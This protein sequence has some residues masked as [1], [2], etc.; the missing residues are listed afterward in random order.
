MK[1]CIL[2]S[3]LA[4]LMIAGTGNAS[5]LATLEEVV[6]TGTRFEREV[7]KIPAH[8]SV[9]TADQIKR[10]GAQTVP[11]VLRG[12]G[13]VSIRD[14]NGNGNNQV[15][16]I[17]GFG[18]TADRHVAVVINGRRVNPID[19]SGI[20]WTL[21]PVAN[22]QRIEILHGSGSVLY[23]DNAM[24]AVINIITKDVREGL[25]V[26]AEAGAGNLDAQRGYGQVHYGKGPVGF[27]L[28]IEGFDT[29]GYRER[30]AAER[31]DG[32]GKVQVY[33][34]DT[35][36]LSLEMNAGKAEYELPGAL[37]EAQR[38]ADRRQAANPAD[39]GQDDEF[40]T[41]LGSEFDFGDYGLLN[42]RLNYREEDIDSDLASWASFVMIES[43][44]DGANVQYV[45]ERDLMGHGNRL[46][47]GFDYYDTEYEAFRGA[48]KGATTNRFR[49][50]KETFGYYAQ[51]ELNI[52]DSLILNVGARYEDPE[53]RLGADLAGFAPNTYVY[54]DSETA[55]H[56][57]LAYNFMPGSKVY[58]RVYESFRYPAVDEFTSLFTG[59]IN[60][61]LKQETA[62]G[63]ELGTRLSLFSRLLLH[64]RLYTMDLENEIAWN[65]LTNQNENLDETRH[66][67]GEADLRFQAF[68]HAAFYGSVGYTDAEF[69]R[70]ANAGKQIPLVPEWKYHAGVDVQYAGF[71]GRLQYN[72]VDSRFF[73]LDY[74]NA[75]KQMDDYQTV[76]L[77]LSYGFKKFDLFF[78]GTNIFGEDYSDYAFYNS[79]GF[80]AF[81]NYYPMPEAVY[82]VGVK[83][84][85]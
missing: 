19:Q 68:R 17:G 67:G 14:L 22:I 41:G 23:G 64:L 81:Y 9:I 11:D 66:Q 15:V 25:S 3:G 21:I 24:G 35:V 20:R 84:S 45:L 44:R 6:V 31:R 16:D 7:D 33:P 55:W 28:G 80:P 83:F 57:G 63:Y 52:L 32:F 47:L 50:E 40:F 13:G 65:P 59:A 1:R 42:V 43:E 48:F 79:F 61:D 2:L 10:S 30:S 78:N 73:G 27:Q 51:D 85:M 49:H 38:N 56:L 70:G 82:L 46:T 29:D 76:D 54:D 71:Q 75:Q 62:E 12:L 18:E 37:T 74:G 36:T 8:V 72:Y 77:Y 60:T 4:L 5:D 34:S 39:E 58:G 69:R 26:D 53:I